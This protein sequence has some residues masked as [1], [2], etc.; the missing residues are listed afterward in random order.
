MPH[1]DLRNRAISEP[2]TPFFCGMSGDLAPS[3]R[4][5][6][7]IAIVRFWC[8]KNLEQVGPNWPIWTDLAKLVVILRFA[9]LDQD[10]R[11]GGLSLRAVAIMTETAI[12]AELPKP[13]KP[14]WWPLGPLFCRTSKRL[15]L[16]LP[17]PL[18]QS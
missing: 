11:K 6:L 3:T 10:V 7:A 2:K 18:K 9:F 1:C 16:E 8:A 12:T 17:K 4:K 15:A 13:S 5:S 14:S